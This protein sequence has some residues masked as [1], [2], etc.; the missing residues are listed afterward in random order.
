MG[1]VNG[2]RG[3]SVGKIVGWVG[4]GIFAIFAM[5]TVLSSFYTLEEYERGVVTRLGNISHVAQPGLNWKVP[6]VDN[7]HIADTRVD[8]FSRNQAVGTKDGQAFEN[9]K[10]TFTHKILTD[11]ASIL[12]LYR[13]FGQSFDYE[14]RVLAELALDRAKAVVGQ[15]PMEEFMP[16]REEIRIKAFNAVREAAEEYGVTVKEVQLADVTF[17]QK[18]KARLEQVAAA[19]ARAE[20][21]KQQAREAEFTANKQIEL[22]RGTAEAKERQA[23]AQAYQTRVESQETAAAIQR[24]G[25][26][27]AAALKAQADVLKNSEGLVALTQAEAM[28]NWN[29]EFNPNVAM[30]GGNGGG[31]GLLPF[32]NLSDQM[33]AKKK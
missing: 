2:K 20:E 27:K 19:R 4:T 15:Y 17:S 22:A 5:V 32:L 28:K 16:K 29:G 6:F 31:A 24:E 8:S 12:N 33:G 18:Y 10:F 11:D 14:G 26:A 21:A 13:Q 23:D 25:E 9:V 3:V 30:F 7:V 1:E